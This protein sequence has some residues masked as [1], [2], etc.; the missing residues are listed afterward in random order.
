M[1]KLSRLKFGQGNAKLGVNTAIFSLPAG[2]TCPGA[3]NCLSRADRKTGKLKEGKHNIFRCYAASAENLFG[4]VRKGRWNNFDKLRGKT[5]PQLVEL[6][7]RSIPRRN[8]HLVRVHSSGDFF[9]QNY[10]DAWVEVAR[11]N[12]HLI[13]YAYTKALPFWVA[14]LGQIPSNMKLVASQGG[15]YDSLIQ[16]H[17][18]R[19]VKVVFSEFEAAKLDLPIDHDDT[20]AWKGDGNFALLLHGVQP[21]DS[22]AAKAWHLIKTKGAGGYQTDYFGHYDNK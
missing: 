7:N 17:N 13:F 4:N 18:L 15:L 3:L 10:F 16:R 9:T 12:P 20:H 19:H 21:K 8:T 6:I 11:L 5:L 2:F 14:R 1:A 22:A